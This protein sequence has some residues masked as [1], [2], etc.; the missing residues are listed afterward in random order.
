MAPPEEYFAGVTQAG[1]LLRLFYEH[2]AYDTFTDETGETIHNPAATNWTATLDGAPIELRGYSMEEARNE[3]RATVVTDQGT[4][5]ASTTG[6]VG[7]H[8]E[9]LRH[10]LERWPSGGWEVA[11][12]DKRQDGAEWSYT[13]TITNGRL[14][15]RAE[16]RFSEQVARIVSDGDP[17]PS[18]AKAT[19]VIAET[20][21]SDKWEK[22]KHRAESPTTLMS[23]AFP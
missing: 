8:S 12:V 11:I 18:D 7:D 4:F 19:A 21:K 9:A 15:E 6:D 14:V 3:Q 17:P 20:I 2:T 22:V 5:T 23:R 1:R 10:H 13:V 16:F